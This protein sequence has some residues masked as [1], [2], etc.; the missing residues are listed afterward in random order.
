MVNKCIIVVAMV[1]PVLLLG[2]VPTTERAPRKQTP[3][4]PEGSPGQQN[5][6]LLKLQQ[7]E[8]RLCAVEV[9]LEKLEGRTSP[10]D[11]RQD[12]KR[13]PGDVDKGMLFDEIKSRLDR[14]ERR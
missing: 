3:A 1:V 4:A 8:K 10:S 5:G 13:A 11:A 6:V 2:G 7:I 9:R 12:A 14:M